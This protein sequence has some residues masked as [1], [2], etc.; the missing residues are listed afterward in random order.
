MHPHDTIVD[1]G[2]VQIGGGRF[3]VI[4]G[5]CAVESRE[6]ML[7][8]ARAV[9]AGGGHALRGGA[10]K[11]RTSPYSFQ[12]LGTEGLAILQESSRDTGLPP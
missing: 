5:P 7:A 12:G 9:R 6:Q 11:P 3:T 2:G 4:A 1:L 10:Y 8:T